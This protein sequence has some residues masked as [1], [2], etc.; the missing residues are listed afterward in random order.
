[1]LQQID[2]VCHDVGV[3]PHAF[4]SAHAHNMQRYT[5]IMDFGGK[6]IDVPFVLCGDGGHN[7]NPLVRGCQERQA[8]RGAAQR[9]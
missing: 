7:V 3:Y 5:R 8:G 1:M 6:E 9:C 2:K 4:L